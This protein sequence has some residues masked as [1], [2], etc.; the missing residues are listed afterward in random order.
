MVVSERRTA[1]SREMNRP[2]AS[3]APTF[4][5]I[6]GLVADIIVPLDRFP[7]LPQE[8]QL[9]AAVTVEPGGLGN[10][11]VVA[12]RLGLRA[13]ALG[14]VGTDVLGAHVC[15]ALAG[16]GVNVS[17]VL[18]LPGA[19][20]T[21]C[22]LV[23]REGRHVFLGSLGVAGPHRCPEDW[24][25]L[26]S[27]SA[28]VMSDGWVAAHSPEPVIEAFTIAARAGAKTVFDPGPLAGR[29]PSPTMEHILSTTEVLLLT[30]EEA[31]QLAEPGPPDKAAR[32][33]LDRGPSMVVIKAGA[34]GALLV[35]RTDMVE[36]PSFPVPVRDTTGAGDAFDA[37]LVASLAAGLSLSQAMT[38]AAAAGALTVS[39]LGTGTALPSRDEVLA[40]AAAHGVF[41]DT[42]P[43][44]HGRER[45][46][47]GDDTSS[48]PGL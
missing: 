33:L 45:R 10:C 8:H 6:G 24:K 46:E 48:D 42:L 28:W 13:T 9:V 5:T 21:S 35:T 19:T 12:A 20:T 37:A 17:H 29:I 43:G 16:E 1:V 40:F 30:L 14:W 39:K 27:Q 23:D 26:V 34:A 31:S 32:A 47:V 2:S 38:L 18:R 7:V 22:V 44:S 41:L 4:A 11:L 3:P 36:Q 25:R 15:S